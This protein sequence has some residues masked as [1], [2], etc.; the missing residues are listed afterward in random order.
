M[1]YLPF[2]GYWFIG[3]TNNSERAS[4]FCSWGLL[5]SAPIVGV[6]IPIFMYY[7]KKLRSMQ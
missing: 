6:V 2:V 5:A 7:Y 4:Y 1:N 3:A